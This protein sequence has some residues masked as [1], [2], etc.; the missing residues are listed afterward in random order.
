[1]LLAQ[2]QVCRVERGGEP[3]VHGTDADADAVRACALNLILAGR[4]LNRTSVPHR[5]VMSVADAA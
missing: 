1:M 2:L 5:G 4:G 3:E